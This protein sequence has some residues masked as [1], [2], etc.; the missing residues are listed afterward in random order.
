MVSFSGE[1]N[2]LF[3]PILLPP[4]VH[5]DRTLLRYHGKIRATLNIDYGSFCPLVMVRVSPIGFKGETSGD[6]LEVQGT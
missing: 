4:G 1:Y 5:Q 6:Y 2:W 3:M